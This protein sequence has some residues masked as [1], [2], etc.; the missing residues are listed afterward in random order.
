MNLTASFLKPSDAVNQ[1]M[2]ARVKL[3]VLSL[4]VSFDLLKNLTLLL[5]SEFFSVNTSVLAHDSGQSLSI[6]HFLNR[7]RLRRS[8]LFKLR[9]FDV[10]FRR[11]KVELYVGLDAANLVI[12]LCLQNID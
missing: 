5:L 1:P 2:F 9:W 3:W 8:L 12:R 11:G 7:S 10:V 4:F 6:L